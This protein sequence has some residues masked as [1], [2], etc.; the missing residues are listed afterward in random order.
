ME[1]SGARRHDERKN[2]SGKS[3][4]KEIFIYVQWRGKKATKKRRE[5]RK[6]GYSENEKICFGFMVFGGESN[7]LTKWKVEV[8]LEG[9]F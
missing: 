4:G 6:K 7:I 5:N 2:V 1:V 8:G 3:E 9:D